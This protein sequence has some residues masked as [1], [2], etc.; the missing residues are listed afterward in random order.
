MR[1]GNMKGVT[2]GIDPFFGHE[3]TPEEVS[4]FSCLPRYQLAL[5][6]ASFKGELINA[7]VAEVT[8][9]LRLLAVRSLLKT[10][11]RLGFAQTDGTGL[12]DGERVR[13]CR[14]TRGLDLPGMRALIAAP[15]VDAE[16]YG[17]AEGYM[18][19]WLAEGRSG[20][21]GRGRSFCG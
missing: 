9:N 6:L 8:N 17:T 15:G 20:C 14:D 4:E 12:V 19:E 18:R 2:A 13:A 21:P 3:P 16:G 5:R 11:Y 7:G 1:P 10:C